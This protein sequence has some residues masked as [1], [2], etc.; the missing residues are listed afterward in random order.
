MS[1][2]I[3]ESVAEA[4]LAAVG[5]A[6]MRHG[7]GRAPDTRNRKVIL[8]GLLVVLVPAFSSSAGLWDWVGDEV[9]RLRSPGLSSL[10][11]PTVVQP[12]SA[13]ARVCELLAD[14]EAAFNQEARLEAGAGRY[15]DY[16]VAWFR[17]QVPVTCGPSKMLVSCRTGQPFGLRGFRLTYVQGRVLVEDLGRYISVDKPAGRAPVTVRFPAGLRAAE[18]IWLL[19][20]QGVSGGERPDW[21]RSICVEAS[22]TRGNQ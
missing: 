17:Y 5:G 10:P 15:E 4:A 13:E 22:P 19:I 12:G 3:I 18:Q 11:A 16:D 21:A 8:A 2:A 1:G 14:A 9:D 6:V 7:C 20:R